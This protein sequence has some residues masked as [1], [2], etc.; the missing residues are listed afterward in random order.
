[1]LV[2][3]VGFMCRSF[4]ILGVRSN[5]PVS[6]SSAIVNNS[7]NIPV[8][9][10]MALLN[11][12]DAPISSRIVSDGISNNEFS[13]DTIPTRKA[14]SMID[15]LSGYKDASFSIK[16]LRFAAVLSNAA[17]SWLGSSIAFFERTNH[18]S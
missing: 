16:K 14:L 3:W 1:M 7:P 15:F 8:C 18:E 9:F 13:S 4:N 2:N 11:S 10:N 5:I 6:D 12:G 17:G